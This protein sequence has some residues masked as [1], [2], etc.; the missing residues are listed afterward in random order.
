M[1]YCRRLIF[2]ESALADLDKVLTRN[3]TVW[4]AALA[5]LQLRRRESPLASALRSLPERGSECD[6][7]I[8]TL[9]NTARATARFFSRRSATDF[10]LDWTESRRLENQLFGPAGELD[11]LNDLLYRE[12]S[13]ESHLTC[14]NA[15]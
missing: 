8:L 4:P 12:C 3:E 2:S 13:S 15:F 5:V 1:A 14:Q 10:A 11:G 9:R 7:L 6:R